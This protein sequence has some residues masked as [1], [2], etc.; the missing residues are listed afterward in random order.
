MTPQLESLELLDG[1]SKFDLMLAL[2]TGENSERHTV[3][4]LL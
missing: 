2:F 4:F 3:R 1:P